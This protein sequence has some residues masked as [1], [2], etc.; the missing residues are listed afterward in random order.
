MA[1]VF[2]CSDEMG[3]GLAIG[4]AAGVGAYIVVQKVAAA[5]SAADVD[6]STT[7]NAHSVSRTWCRI[8]AILGPLRAVQCGGARQPPPPSAP[9][10]LRSL[11]GWLVGLVGL[12]GRGLS[13][14]AFQETFVSFPDL[15]CQLMRCCQPTRAM[16]TRPIVPSQSTCS[17]TTARTPTCF[18]I[19]TALQK[20][21]TSRAG[22]SALGLPGASCSDGVVSVGD[23]S[24][25]SNDV[26][27]S[28]AHSIAGR[29]TCAQ[30][31]WS[32]SECRAGQRLT[33]A[34][35]WA[36]RPSTSRRRLTRFSGSTSVT[37]SS[38]PLTS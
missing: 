15:C 8:P 20:R 30:S 31:G 33:L 1:K 17:S 35:R 18:R 9:C 10:C 13:Q 2:G 4:A 16:S 19:P 11:H 34:A 29:Q 26:T 25:S 27:G 12:A 3:R 38:Q 32:S 14:C 36:G 7:S 21:S 24:A 23:G 5:I 22:K 37:S 6:F 28:H